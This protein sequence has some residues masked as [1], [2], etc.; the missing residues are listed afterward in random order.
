MIAY[1]PIDRESLSG[2]V[3][4]LTAEGWASYTKDPEVTWKALTAPGVT[5]I[6]AKDVA[7]IVGFAQMMGD[8]QIAAFLSLLIV[9]AEYRRQG[10]GRELI[11]E[12]F[13]RTGGQRVDL[14]TDT[15]HDFYRSFP[16]HEIPGYRIYPQGPP[17]GGPA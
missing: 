11:R 12:A 6:V 7:R 13:T 17:K 4:L 1:Q 15:A 8:G 3:A 2:V 5:T 9:D 16:H 14:L 10:I